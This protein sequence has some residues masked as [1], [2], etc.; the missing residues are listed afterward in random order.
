MRQAGRRLARW[1]AAS[2]RAACARRPPAHLHTAQ[3]VPAA[4]GRAPRAAGRWHRDHPA[5]VD[6]RST[7][8]ARRALRA[9]LLRTPACRCGVFAAAAT[10]LYAW[11]GVPASERWRAEPTRACA[12]GTGPGAC[13]RSAV[14]VRAGGVHGPLH[15]AG[16][17]AWLDGG[18]TASRTLRRPR[19]QTCPRCRQRVRG[20]TGRQRPRGAGAG[21]L[22]H[23]QCPAR[24]RYRG[25][26]VVRTRHVWRLSDRRAG[27]HARSPRQRAQRRR[28]RHQSADH[29]VLFAQ[30]LAA[31]GAG[32]LN[33]VSAAPLQL[34]SHLA[35]PDASLAFHDGGQQSAPS[36]TA[37]AL[38][39][40]HQRRDLRRNDA[41]CRVTR[42]RYRA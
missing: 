14:S 22:Q 38:S 20:G 1:V 21:R 8:S 32:S 23:R 39:C 30:P 11:A 35:Q 15:R 18:A 33:A 34:F 29:R 24:C 10:R 7:G 13:M 36:R 2:V 17:G 26:A 28:T 3:S 16:E 40:V 12:R 19:A 5:A 37:R 41:R 4:P 31:V 6:G 9:A 42:P 25:A 27:W